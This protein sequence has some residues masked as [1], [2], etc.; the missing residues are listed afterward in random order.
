MEVVVGTLEDSGPVIHDTRSY[1]LGTAE[2]VPMLCSTGSTVRLRESLE[3]RFSEYRPLYLAPAGRPIILGSAATKLAWLEV[4]GPDFL[5]PYDPL[6]VH[7]RIMRVSYIDSLAK[8][9]DTDL[10]AARHL[11]QPNS[12]D[13]SEF[14]RILSGLIAIR[15]FLERERKNEFIVCCK[16]TRYGLVWRLALSDGILTR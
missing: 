5:R 10:D 4:R 1:K 2:L 12:N 8:L 11:I 15:A 7:G 14:Q 3:R 16:G 6:M 9:A 13:G